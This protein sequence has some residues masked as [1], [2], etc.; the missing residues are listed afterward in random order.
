MWPA[1]YRHWCGGAFL[2]RRR[3]RLSQWLLAANLLFLTACE[4]GASGPTDTPTSGHI[5]I[6]ADISLK[7]ALDPVLEQF[8]R[9]YKYAHVD[10]VY[11]SEAEAVAGLLADSF[12]VAIVSRPFSP[13]DSAVLAEQKIRPKQTKIVR[14]GIA[15]IGHPSRTD[16][17]LPVDTLKAWL[18][19]P[20]A[21]Y[22]F[23]I[24]G[25]GGSGILRF[26]RDTLLGGKMPAAKL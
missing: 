17:L 9:T 5:T 6:A 14:E 25:G 4:G 3:V 8:H 20:N 2:G 13:A 26:L 1:I 23:V 19:N 7:P 18:L 11:T 22:T 12:R 15:I 24:E 21:I 16:S 10:V